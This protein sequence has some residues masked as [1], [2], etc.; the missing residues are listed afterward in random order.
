MNSFFDKVGDVFTRAGEHLPEAL[1]TLV[2]GVVAVEIA[3]VVLSV[4]LR[5]VKMPEGLRRILQSLGR[6]F[7]WII[8]IVVLMQTFGLNSVV[9]AITGSSVVVA[10][11]LSTGVAPIVTDV[12]AGLFLGSD[13]DFRVGSLVRAGDKG[14][15]GVI[16]TMDIRKVR[17]RDKQ[18]RLHIVPNSLIEKNEWVVID[19]HP[20]TS[21]K[22]ASNRSTK[23]GK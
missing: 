17:L 6:A 8:L 11:L 1:L 3:V 7:L 10:L 2:V 22:A 13:P 12:L 5:W 9:V 4:V 18:G 21:A 19:R 20:G 16:A 14:A 23:R 15:E